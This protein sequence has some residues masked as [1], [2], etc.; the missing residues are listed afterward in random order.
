MSEAKKRPTPCAGCKW[1]DW[2][3]TA[4]GRLHP[5]GEGQCTHPI[6][7]DLVRQERETREAWEADMRASGKSYRIGYNRS[8]LTKLRLPI[9]LPKVVIVEVLRASRIERTGQHAHQHDPCPTR[10]ASDE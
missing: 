1:A 3:R 10:E 2:K 5:D 6:V 8:P 9:A 7:E 4:S